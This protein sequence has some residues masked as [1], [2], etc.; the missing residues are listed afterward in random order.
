MTTT[1]RLIHVA[2]A[3]ILDR[4]QRILLARRPDDKHQGGL[5]EFP[6]GKVEAGESAADALARELHEELG[7]EVRRARPLIQIPHHYADKSVLLDVFVVDAFDGQ[8][9]GRE[10]QPVR[11]V[12]TAELSDYRFPAANRPILAAARLPARLLI[13]GTAQAPA[14]YVAR[15][16]RAL[17]MGLRWVMLRAPELADADFCELYRQLLGLCD[18]AGAT[19]AVNCDL[20][21]ANRLEARALHL[22]RHRLA[23]LSGRDAFKGEWLSASCHDEAELSRAAKLGLDFVTLSPVAPT[24]SH[25][26]AELLGWPGF[27]RLCAQATLPVYALGGMAEADLETAWAQGGQGVAAISAWWD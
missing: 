10:G 6:G 7:I 15:T 25:P 24:P 1:R 18:A 2:A 5:W 20:A 13:T 19:L 11:W 23:Q 3:V 17:A 4:D 14:E 8:A 26:E 21:L 27:A 12:H 22:N 16:E 9:H